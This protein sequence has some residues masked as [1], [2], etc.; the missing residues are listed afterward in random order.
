MA[1]YFKSTKMENVEFED[2]N[3]QKGWI[4]TND[5]IYPR[6]KGFTLFFV[7]SEPNE[8]CILGFENRSVN[9]EK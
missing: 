7:D 3:R 5:T 8:Q 4:D 1:A 2:I 6:Y 9:H